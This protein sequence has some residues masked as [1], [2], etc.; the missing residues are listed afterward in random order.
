MPEV[1]DTFLHLLAKVHEGQ[2]KC[3][4]KNKKD[5]GFEN[6]KKKD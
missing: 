3:Y 6:V 4:D 1:K 2:A 5:H